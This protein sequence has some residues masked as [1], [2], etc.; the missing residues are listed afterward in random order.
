MIGGGRT[1][2]TRQGHVVFRETG[3]WTASVHAL[4]RHLERVGFAAS[5]RVVGSGFDARGRETLTY[6]EG[7]IIHPA[8]WSD[9]AIVAIGRTIR[10]LHDATT[11][12][13][14]PEAAVWRP[15]FGRRIGGPRRVIGHC[16]AAPWNIVARAGKPVALIDWEVAGPV[17]PLTELA[18]IAW[19]NAQLYDDDVAE[20]NRLPGAAAR[21]HQVRLLADA[22]ELPAADRRELTGRIIEFVAQSAA[23]EVIEQGIT[24]QTRYAPRVWG[25]AWQT[26]SV[27]WILRNRP[28]LEHALA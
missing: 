5:P 19:N 15:W 12:F 10:Q 23:N 28:M 18:Q 22:Y 6:I 13:H 7:E 14:I 3:A 16:D 27:A 11:S 24:P 26:R 1:A 25:I 4:L 17:D 2:V 21:M 20:M 9:D 8:P